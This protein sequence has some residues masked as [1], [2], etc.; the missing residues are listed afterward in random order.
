MSQP[1]LTTLPYLLR[2]VARP[3]RY[4]GG[5]WGSVPRDWDGTAVRLCIVYPDVY[6]NGVL[7]PSVNSLYALLNRRPDVLA[8]RVFA[9]W[10]DYAAALRPAGTPLTSLESGTPLADFDVLAVCYPHELAAPTILEALDLGSVPVDAAE[11]R[12]GHPLVVGWE[13]EPR[14]PEPLAPFLDAYLLGDADAAIQGVVDALAE[15]RGPDGAGPGRRGLLASLA[16]LPGVYVPSL[17]EQRG[18]GPFRPVGGSAAPSAVSRAVW[19]D[20]SSAPAGSVVPHLQAAPDRPTVEADRGCPPD[21]EGVRL[22]LHW[23][24]FRARSAE[25]VAQ[26]VTRT[27]RDTGFQ[28]MALGSACLHLRSD[29][30]ELARAVRGAAHAANVQFRLPALAPDASS[31]GILRELRNT[32]Q[33]V[34]IGPV[35]LGA[36]VEGAWM[37]A[38]GEALADCAARGGLGNVRLAAVL[39]HPE[40]ETP[41]PVERDGAAASRWMRALPASHRQLR[42][43]AAFFVP[44][45]FTALER[46]G[47]ADTDEMSRQFA[48]LRASLGRRVQVSVDR[49]AGAARV[50]AAVARGGRETA[51]A[52]RHAW[53]LGCYLSGSTESPW[54][55]DAWQAAFAAAGLSID[56]QAGRTFADAEPLPWD[57]LAGWRDPVLVEGV[58]LED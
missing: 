23:G 43:D 13:E 58:R 27:A 9:P 54:D 21:C 45:A 4:T 12:V 24:P 33:N 51:E 49:E 48:E 44:R 56:A 42:V 57:H 1:Y 35:V 32:K 52:V 38:M 25:A 11:R 26:A 55:A 5:E 6:E 22:G 47:Q 7:R 39:G 18:D 40:A 14:N 30:T 53:K 19:R 31:A 3:A 41:A 8:E 28:E 16:E 36:G 2:R 46:T 20:L 29:R 34:T 37:D 17:Y 50:G 15:R 10:P